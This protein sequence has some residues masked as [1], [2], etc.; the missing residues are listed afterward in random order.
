MLKS[1]SDLRGLAITAVDGAIGDVETY[2]FDDATWTIRYLVVN[3]GSWLESKQVLIS[4][5]S[6]R[7][8]DV[9]TNQIYV[10]LTMK[11]V[12]NSP[13]IDTHKPVSRQQE[14]KFLDHYGYP[15]YW[16]GPFLW[17][18]AAAPAMAAAAPMPARQTAAELQTGRV[19]RDPAD[20]RLRSTTE[21]TGYHIQ[22]TDGEIG[23]VEDFIVD[24]ET[25]AVRYLVIDTSNWWFGKKVLISPQWIESISWTESKVVVDLRQEEIKNS[26]EYDKEN[27]VTREYETSLHRH[28]N[29]KGYWSD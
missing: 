5:L 20:A 27:L 21:I 16:G 25:W 23:H 11:Q 17:G 15:Y 2:Y 24:E 22:A 6:I 19:E 28:Y 3:T 14:T 12:K 9:I 13:N 26:P 8:V 29:R 10:D 7:Q 4:P 1:T 18:A